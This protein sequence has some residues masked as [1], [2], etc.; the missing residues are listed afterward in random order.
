MAQGERG[1]GDT[2]TAKRIRATM[3]NKST[4]AIH[5]AE[6]VLETKKSMG[7]FDNAVKRMASFGN[8]IGKT[9]DLIHLTLVGGFVFLTMRSLDRQY[10]IENLENERASLHMENK[11][12]EKKIWT[13]KQGLL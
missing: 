9:D 11:S 12:L 1:V 2:A 13:L 8:A 5:A 3:W 7:V 6:A 10:E 4:A